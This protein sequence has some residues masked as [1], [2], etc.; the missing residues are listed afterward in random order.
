MKNNVSFPHPVLGV[1]DSV[2]PVLAPDCV[3]AEPIER[4]ENNYIFKFRLH[5]ENKRIQSYIDCGMA[6]YVCEVDCSRTFYTRVYAQGGPDFEIKIPYTDVDGHVDITF[7]IV[8]KVGIPAYSNDFNPDYCN[9][10]GTNP[11]FFIHSGDILVLFPRM[12]YNVSVNIDNMFAVGSFMQIVKAADDI[13][14]VNFNLSNDIINIELPRDMFEQYDIFN[15][16]DYVSIVHASLVFNALVYALQNINEAEYEGKS[17]SDSIKFIIQTNPMLR[18]LDYSDL[19]NAFEIA[20]IMLGDPYR[21]LF[22][23]L[24]SI[25]NNDT[26]D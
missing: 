2:L 11:S 13:K 25:I 5:Q 10:D 9:D 1:N 26:T 8:S 21:R 6:D 16:T 20:T 18:D 3:K 15:D 12:S 4:K 14:T 17:W 22:D 7:Y 24:Y 19:N 23:G